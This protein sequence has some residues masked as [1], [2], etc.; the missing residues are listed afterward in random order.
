MAEVCSELVDDTAPRASEG[1]A[2]L[3]RRGRPSLARSG[4]LCGRA[5]PLAAVPPC[6]ARSARARAV[7]PHRLRFP[8]ARHQSAAA[9]ARAGGA[10]HS[11]RRGRDLAPARGDGD[12]AGCAS[13]S[14]GSSGC[15][16]AA[17][18][19][20]MMAQVRPRARRLR[21]RSRHAAAPLWRMHLTAPV[22]VIPTGVDTSY[23]APGRPEPSGPPRIVFTGSMDWLPNVDAR[24]CS[25]VARSCRSSAQPSPTSRSR[26]VG[27]SPTP[28][29]RRLAEEPRHRGN[30]P[31]R[32]CPSVSRAVGRQRR[33]PAHRRRHA[34]EDLRSD[35]GGSCRGLD[36]Q[37][38]PRA[39][40][41]NTAGTCCS[42]TTRW[43]S[44]AR[45]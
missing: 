43:P 30:R 38:G 29:V 27:R 32:R 3:L 40:R 5:V 17:S 44:R 16:C 34:T 9:P 24:A 31:R 41:P 22:S 45:S 11:Q 2:A 12:R 20:E 6:G 4:A 18:K 1:R 26:I 37:S 14:T 42:P 23:F 36:Q 8:R 33:A 25:S 39:C 13:A 21:R 7:R 10:L 28:A 19:A 15:G 35:G